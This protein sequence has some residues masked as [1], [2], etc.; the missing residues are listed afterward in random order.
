MGCN[1]EV[2]FACDYD[3][4]SGAAVF[5]ILQMRPMV[6]RS[7]VKKVSLKDLRPENLLCLSAQALGNGAHRDIADLIYVIPEKFDQLK[8]REIAEEIG[9]M[10]ARLREEGRPY[11]VIGP[12]RWGSSDPSLGIPVKWHHIS[13][14][15]IIIEAAYGDFVVDPSYGTHFFHNVTSLGI[16]YF[17][18]NET[19]PEAFINWDKIKAE[20]P[21]TEANYIRHIRFPGPLD[22]RID[23]S[24]GRAAVAI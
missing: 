24:E 17:T 2:E 18:I 5:K 20:R 16:G 14:S 10:N 4:A 23:G 21:L 1:V 8:T 15:R 6:S 3:P 7:P 19:G 13:G 11:L 12:G 9:V 22:I